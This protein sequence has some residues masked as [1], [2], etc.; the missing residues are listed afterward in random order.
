[1]LIKS[2]GNKGALRSLRDGLALQSN[3]APK[4]PLYVAR[5]DLADGDPQRKDP[6]EAARW[7]DY[8][9]ALEN[10]VTCFRGF[11]EGTTGLRILAPEWDIDGWYL[12]KDLPE[13]ALHESLL[14]MYKRVST[15]RGDAE[16]RPPRPPSNISESDFWRLRSR[17]FYSALAFAHTDKELKN[18]VSVVLLLE[19]RG[20]R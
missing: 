14:G 3:I 18:N 1:L 12:G 5:K 11:T 4:Y 13:V 9:M 7:Q 8:D 15:T 19:W 17:M 10:G 20:R 16:R 2:I 6:I